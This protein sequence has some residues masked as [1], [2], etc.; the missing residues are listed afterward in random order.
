MV[1]VVLIAL[2]I[3]A[4]VS[5]INLLTGVVGSLSGSHAP[6]IIVLLIV[7]APMVGV[8]FL[9]FRSIRRGWRATPVLVSLMGV[10]ALSTLAYGI[11]LLA[12][13]DGAAG[14]AMLVAGWT[15]SA[16]VYNRE[17]RQARL[18]ALVPEMTQSL[19]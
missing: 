15:P 7:I 1:V 18:D 10:W 12:V 8:Y 11:D 9:V 2:L 17:A 3:D 16:R 13:F 19:R 14:V 4:I 6:S 5:A